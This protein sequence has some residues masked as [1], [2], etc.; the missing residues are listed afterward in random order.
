MTDNPLEAVV[1]EDLRKTVKKAGGLCFK[2]PA[3]LYIGIPDRLVLLPGGKIFFVE[4]KR[5][6][7][8]RTAAMQSRFQEILCSLG[9]TC[10]ILKGRP[11][12]D[13]FVRTHVE[14]R[15]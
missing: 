13:N 8:S 5:K 2:L 7:N 3:H 1:E 12:L 9:F 15:L 4:L 6:R 14:S 10:V 11:D